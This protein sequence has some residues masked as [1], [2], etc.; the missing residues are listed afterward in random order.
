MV[1][2]E[3]LRFAAML[4]LVGSG[5]RLTSAMLSDRDIGKAL[6]FAY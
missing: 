1:L 4:I 3:A 5:I 6:A 2:V